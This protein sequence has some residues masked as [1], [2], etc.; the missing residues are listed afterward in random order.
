MNKSFPFIIIILSVA[1]LF[2]P[3]WL[4]GKICAPLDIVT[5]LYAPWA[6]VAEQVDVQNH[7]VTDSPEQYLLYM[8]HAY[9]SEHDEHQFGW[10]DLKNCGTPAYANTMAVPFSWRL[11]LFRFL[12]FWTA[13]HLGIIGQFLIAMCGMFLFLKVVGY[14]DS[15][16][17]IG[18][19]AFGFC[20][21]FSV[22]LYHL[23]AGGLAWLPWICWSVY[24]ARGKSGWGVTAPIFLALG[25]SGVHLQYA[26]FFIIA[27]GC[28]WLGWLWEEK[29][30]SFC[31]KMQASL[32]FFWLGI[33]GILL[34]AVTFVPCVYAYVNTLKFGL[35][36]G[37]GFYPH[38]ILSPFLNVL[39]YP[40]FIFPQILG[41]PH[42]FDVSK[43]FDLNLMDIPY[44]GSLLVFLAFAGLFLPGLNRTAKI[45]ALTGLIFPLTPLVG[46][47]YHRLLFFFI[48]G[49]IWLAVD[50]LQNLPDKRWRLVNKL[51][52]W[53]FI[54]MSFVFLLASLGIQY[55]Q[56]Q[57]V[58]QLW[59][60]LLPYIETHRFAARTDWFHQRIQ[61]FISEGEIWHFHML[62]P[63]LLFGATVYLLRFRKKVFFGWIL[64]VLIGAQLWLYD[65]DWI[66]FCDPLNTEGSVY[67]RVEEV[68]AVQREVGR[69]GRVIVAQMPGRLPLFP[70]NSLSSFN[71]PCVVG[72]DSILPDG[73]QGE[74]PY[75]PVI[76]VSLPDASF[77]GKKGV[78]HLITYIDDK[79]PGR[80]WVRTQIS[81][82]IAVYSNTFARAWYRIETAKGLVPVMPA[83]HKYNFRRLNLPPGTKKVL[84]CENW[85]EGWQFRVNDGDWAYM[86]R[87]ANHSMF[88]QFRPLKKISVF[89]MR[90]KPRMLQI[91]K[92]ISLVSLILY[93]GAAFIFLKK[94]KNKS[95]ES[96]ASLGATSSPP[97][98]KCNR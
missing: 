97:A 61:R 35:V 27:I 81:G 2:S 41:T 32:G 58:E 39:G 30:T 83:Q 38:G 78:T 34:A 43:V 9:R 6:D 77:L 52:G 84:L 11:Q 88:A 19:L 57:L 59:N 80:G 69:T 24:K 93:A 79:V 73:I 67:P 90:Y 71:I 12:P 15:L 76:G 53:L 48:F 16:A 45:F 56:V 96:G 66:V 20:A 25:F 21:H 47:L 10:N 62:F 18:A 37:T 22:W 28:L 65:R 92:I 89:E 3:Y 29:Q 51:I 13:W 82:Q 95:V 26:A 8:D 36:R 42:S 98:G 23:W 40:F 55:F 94:L 74:I 50:L 72:Y 31:R 68:Q 75:S 49:G 14:D 60:T 54:S 63:W 87:A 86:K 17:V 44:F 33:V 4:R 70:L 46:P 64:T 5:N 1:G 91:G 7:Y 85:D